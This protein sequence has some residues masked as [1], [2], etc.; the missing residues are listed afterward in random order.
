MPVTVP[1]DHDAFRGKSIDLPDTDSRVTMKVSGFSPEQ[2]SVSLA[3][4]YNSIWISWI[5]GYFIFFCLSQFA[6]GM[7]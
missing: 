6:K 2:I 4:S 7:E 5:T 3:A 1:L